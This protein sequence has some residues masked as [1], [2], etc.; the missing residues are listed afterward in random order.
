[1]VV[2]VSTPSL[3][4]GLLGSALI[5]S[6][7]SGTSTSTTGCEWELYSALV[8]DGFCHQAFNNAECGYDGGDC[9]ECTCV[10]ASYTCGY[11]GFACIDPSAVCVDDDNITEGIAEG[12]SDGGGYVASIGDGYCSD[13]NNIEE[14]DYDGG[15]CCEC[16]CVDAFYPCGYVAFACIDPSAACV[17]D[18]NITADIA[19]SCHDGGGYVAGLGN[20]Y[21]DEANNIEECG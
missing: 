21:C 6:S 18:D 5:M 16:T 4:L 12:C 20:G 3:S 14:C 9:C 2:M 7:G 19:E 11:G 13:E 10:D 17:D 15:D 1:M 8:A